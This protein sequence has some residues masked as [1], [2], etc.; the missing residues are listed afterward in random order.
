MTGDYQT[1]KR[2]ALKMQ[3][4][5]LPDF[6]GKSVLD[7]GTDHG[8]WTFLAA[9]QGAKRV[10]GLDRN[11]VVQGVETD[12]ILLNREERNRRRLSQVVAF[13]HINLGKQWH[14]YLRFDIA[15]CFSVYHHWY[16][17]CG[18]HAAI[19][20]WLSRCTQ[21][22]LWEGPTGD[23]DPVVR[24]NI[25]EAHRPGYTRDAI[26]AAASK[27][28][29]A[30]FIGP[31]LHEPTR[32][33]WRFTARKTPKRS[34]WSGAMI[35]GA[36][37]A[38]KAFEYAENRRMDEMEEI[39]GWRPFPGS[40]NI[41]LDKPFDWNSGYYRAQVLD[42]ADRSKGLSSPWVSRWARFYP[43]KMDGI[44]AMAFRFEGE[45]YRAYFMELIAP[46]KLRDVCAGPDVTICSG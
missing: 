15:L 38:T 31:A 30:E 3:A 13:E 35:D 32:E 7:I 39:L 8:Y 5:P 17:C 20:F 16:E 21:T 46:Q 1:E 43:V 4:I 6:K 45:Q 10:L 18:D 27:H 29:H 42:V 2:M 44:P 33:V 34:T 25:S 40:L 12:L 24:A 14:E 19:W 41:Q 26:I 23:N 36:G 28:Y 11:R 22:V 37:G 9:E